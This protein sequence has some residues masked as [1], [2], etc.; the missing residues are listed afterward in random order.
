M[1]ISGPIAASHLQSSIRS[2]QISRLHCCPLL[3][4]RL[5]KVC[6]MPAFAL[7]LFKKHKLWKLKAGRVV[8]HAFRHSELKGAR[9]NRFQAFLGVANLISNFRKYM[10][11]QKIE[12]RKSYQMGA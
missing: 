2:H 12:M 1:C 9:K 4:H 8:S 11:G 7:G 10:G 6:L 3:A 5:D